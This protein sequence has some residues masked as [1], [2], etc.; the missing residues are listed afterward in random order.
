MKRPSLTEVFLFGEISRDPIGELERALNS[1]FNIGK[2]TAKYTDGTPMPQSPPVK[3]FDRSSGVTDELV[4]IIGQFGADRIADHVG[5]MYTHVFAA[6]AKRTK[7]AWPEFDPSVAKALFP[8]PKGMSLFRGVVVDSESAAAQWKIGQAQVATSGEK[9]HQSSWTESAEVAGS[10]SG[11]SKKQSADAAGVSMVIR[12]IDPGD[13]VIVA[14][15]IKK[16][17]AWFR[18]A[19]RA[20]AKSDPSMYDADSYWERSEK[21][22]E[23]ILSV[24]RATVEVVEKQDW[25]RTKEPYRNSK[26]PWNKWQRQQNAKGRVL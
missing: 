18:A 14:P 25:G 10:F 17:P 12:L 1:K 7:Q 20:L 16:M 13:A 4:P 5:L 21:H 26:E 2:R 9:R 15:P 23:W 3:I 22:D 24:S 19:S 6:G 11:I 8:F